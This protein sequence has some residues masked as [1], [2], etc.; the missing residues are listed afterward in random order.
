[1]CVYVLVIVSR[2][3]EYPSRGRTSNKR[4]W[5]MLHINTNDS[6]PFPRHGRKMT[7]VPTIYCPKKNTKQTA[8][9]CAF[10]YSQ[11]FIFT[12]SSRISSKSQNRYLSLQRTVG[13]TSPCY[14]L[15]HVYRQKIVAA[16]IRPP[17][18]CPHNFVPD[19][20]QQNFLFKSHMTS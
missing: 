4:T 20:N 12:F 5:S 15:A 7:P 6:I 17:N 18:L 13:N 8:V 1:M 11:S 19:H 14:R 9:R 16:N 2:N 10:L 3:A